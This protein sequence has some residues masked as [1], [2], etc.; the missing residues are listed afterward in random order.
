[1]DKVPEDRAKG[2]QTPIWT[3]YQV[4]IDNKE[5]TQVH[6]LGISNEDHYK[7]LDVYIVGGCCDSIPV[8]HGEIGFV[9]NCSAGLT[10]FKPLWLRCTST[11]N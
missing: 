9:T 6:I 5:A 4:I 3:E 11:C 7:G 1:M 8:V 10:C 2:L